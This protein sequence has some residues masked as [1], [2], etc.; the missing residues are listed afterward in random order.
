MQRSGVA[1]IGW[2]DFSPKHRQRVGAVLDML[3]PE[4][5]VDELG[6]GTIRDGLA[7]QMFPG[8]STVQT[9]AK[10]FFIIS[11][12]LYEYQRLKPSKRSEKS[13][14]QYLEDEEYKI[15]WELAKRYNHEDGHGVIGITKRPPETIMRRPSAIYWTGLIFYRFINA[16]GLSLD[17]FLKQRSTS[18]E[19]LLAV[20][21]QGDD[22]PSDDADADFENTFDLKVPY[23]PD[24]KEALRLEL[25]KSEAD[26]FSDQIRETA[27]D[28][29]I[30]KL[31]MDRDFY[32][33]FIRHGNFGDFAKEAVRNRSK[34]SISKIMVLA[35]DFSEVMHGAHITYNSLLQRAKFNKDP[36]REKWQAWS[37]SLETKMIDFQHFDPE[38][39]F[40]YA[41][42]TRS[43]TKTF[44]SKWWQFCRGDR[45][46]E[47]VR[48]ELIRNQEKVI[49][50]YKARIFRNRLSDVKEEVW[51]GL[52][53]LDYRY[54]NVKKILEDVKHPKKSE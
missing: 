17:T 30:G 33:L 10:Y 9:R 42:T 5:V 46:A 3:K 13:P 36:F 39:L 1:E 12:I 7:D 23:D 32:A 49:K 25:S 2:I 16:A 26:F 50:N 28:K 44:I 47:D 51:I 21:K 54:L 15:M 53:Y 22:C 37:E 20:G 40:L 4:G 43:Q 19:S 14:T 48:S 31:V 18:D 11:Y 41:P 52:G 24:W 27:K 35:H 8:I 38:V 29:L 6:V 45:R 34:E